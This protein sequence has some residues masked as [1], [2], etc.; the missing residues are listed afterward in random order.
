MEILDLL[1]SFGFTSYESS[2]YLALLSKHPSNGSQVSRV[3]GVARSRIYDVLRGLLKRGLVF[4]VEVGKYVPLPFEE[5]QKQLRTQFETNLNS[6]E[7]QLSK[8]F[9]DTSHEF[10]FTLQGYENVIARA[11][12]IIDKAQ[13][14]LYLRMFPNSWKR[15]RES[16]QNALSRGVGI[17]LICMGEMPKIC[18]LQIT[19]PEN[20][21]LIKKLGGESLDIVSD[22]T[23]TLVGIFVSNQID[24]SPF[25]WSQNRWFVVANRDSLRHDYYHY[26]LDKIYEQGE[27]MSNHDKQIYEFIKIDD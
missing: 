16:I 4:E 18:D 15:L 24:N 27:N 11:C 10:I 14:E 8:Q 3:S 5:L 2:A 22:K 1:K 7:E 6:L 12:E 26:F 20:Q 17:R 19:H 21:N 25:I 13:K 23:E 9:Q